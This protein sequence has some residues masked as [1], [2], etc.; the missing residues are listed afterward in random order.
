MR[1]RS[2]V[3]CGRNEYSLS[4]LCIPFP[5][6]ASY[7]ASFGLAAVPEARTGRAALASDLFPL[8]F[9]QYCRRY[10]SGRSVG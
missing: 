1:W 7:I 10:N 4:L 8:Y 5:Y 2:E 6:E 3:G 9:R